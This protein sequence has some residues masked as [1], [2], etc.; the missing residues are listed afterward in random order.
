MTGMLLSMS[1]R[2]QS[3]WRHLITG[4]VRGVQFG[5]SPEA[6]L[7]AGQETTPGVIDVLPRINA[8]PGRVGHRTL[9]R[10][11]Q[12][13]VT[14]RQPELHEDAQEQLAL[15]AGTCFTYALMQLAVRL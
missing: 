4:R 1:S 8:F 6:G 12:R 15:Q 10:A 2:P 7:R 3:A 11:R 13:A 14:V 5:C 9:A